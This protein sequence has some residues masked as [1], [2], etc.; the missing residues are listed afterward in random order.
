[1][2]NILI[3]IVS[4]LI[5]CV[6]MTA[7]IHKV[8]RYTKDPYHYIVDPNG[9]RYKIQSDR[10]VDGYIVEN[11]DIN[12][13]DL[14]LHVH[15]YRTVAAFEAAARK[16]NSASTYGIQTEGFTIYR[17]ENNVCDM[18]IYDPAYQYKPEFI[19]HELVHCIYGNFHPNQNVGLPKK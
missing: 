16:Y 8:K 14:E 3:V 17:R 19:G 11:A 10:G 2:R 5:G 6:A 1:M 7:V 18:H 9:G 15:T 4:M 12:H 13:K